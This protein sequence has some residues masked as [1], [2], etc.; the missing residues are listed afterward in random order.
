MSGKTPEQMKIKSLDIVIGLANAKFTPSE[1][2]TVLAM[3]LAIMAKTAGMD[4]HQIV[5]KFITTL[6]RVSEEMNGETPK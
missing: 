4:N 5:D 6:K 3:T 1:G 2:M